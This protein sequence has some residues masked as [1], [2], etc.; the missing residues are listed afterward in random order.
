[1]TTTDL[2]Y[3]L[4]FVNVGLYNRNFFGKSLQVTDF[5]NA[6]TEFTNAS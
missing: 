4:S 1:M 3:A 2:T 6:K 5:Y